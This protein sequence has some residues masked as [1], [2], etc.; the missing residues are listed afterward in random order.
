MHSFQVYYL[1]TLETFLAGLSLEEVLP[2]AVELAKKYAAEESW[3]WRRQGHPEK[4]WGRV[5]VGLSNGKGA[6]AYVY[7][8]GT[9][10]VL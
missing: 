10:E 7:Q 8:D 2:Q 4:H 9:T 3:N 1:G 5:W 6:C